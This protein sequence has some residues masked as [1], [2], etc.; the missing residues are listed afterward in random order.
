MIA[1]VNG[2]EHANRVTPYPRPGG[3][4]FWEINTASHI[5]WPQQSRVLEILDNRDGG[6]LNKGTVSIVSTV[7]DHGAAA[8]PGSGEGYSVGRLASISR[9]LSYNDVHA[10]NGED[11]TS[12]ARGSAQDRNVVLTV[13]DPR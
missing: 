10:N 4:G 1:F 8:N 3:G 5:D 7:L 6:L 9:E 12:D 11:G 13:P 2:H